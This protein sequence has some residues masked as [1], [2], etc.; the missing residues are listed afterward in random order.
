MSP[1]LGVYLHIPFC[2]KKCFYCDFTSQAGAEPLYEV[3]TA[4]LGREIAG[5]GGVLSEMVVDTV[6]I[7]GGTP[8][9][10]PVGDLVRVIDRLRDYCR[11]DEAAEFTVE[12]NPGTL[13]RE[14]LAALRKAGV[15]RLSIGVQAFDAAVLTT[16]GRIHSPA[17]AAA[18]I[19][20][21]AAEGFDNISIDL[22][23]GLPGQSA[24]SFAA[25]LRQAVGLPVSHISAYGL[26][27]EEGT[28]FAAALAQGRL[29]LP[30]EAEEEAMYQAAVHFLPEQ[31][32]G[33]YEIS[34]FAKPGAECRHNLKYWRYQP[35]LGLGTAAHS[36][37][38]G[39][40][41]ANTA[42]LGEYIRRLESDELPVASRETPTGA[43]AIAEYAFLALRTVQGLSLV[44]FARHFGQ[45]FMGLYG[46]KV[47]K[48]HAQGLLSTDPE[49]IRLTPLG[50]KYGNIAFAS[51]LPDQAE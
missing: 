49:G 32:F 40:R 43:I 1:K 7:G 20:L 29:R 30:D 9:V 34:N 45:D 36:F 38:A 17:A 15:T 18:T 35:Y 16:A 33:R 2:L 51:F 11:F 13:N 48:L 42:D 26:K 28:P 47:E 50:M 21:A 5:R 8:T 10:L 6:Y 41:I 39:E 25:G 44:E 22:M 23:Y 27:V 46:V 31:G 37:L 14:K 19:E 12:A 24:E 4:A 3:Y